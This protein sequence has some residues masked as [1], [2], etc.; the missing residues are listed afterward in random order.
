MSPSPPVP[1]DGRGLPNGHGRRLLRLA[2]ALVAGPLLALALLALMQYLVTQPRDQWLE[3]QERPAIDFVRVKSETAPVET[4]RRTPPPEPELEPPP[5]TPSL[6]MPD[7]ARP[8]MPP[9]HMGVGAIEVPVQVAEAP[10]LGQAGPGVAAGSGSRDVMAISRTP[11]LYPISA[12]RRGI[13]GW[14]ELAFTVTAAGSVKDVEVV[15][16]EPP[17]VFD[18][19]AISAIYRWKFRPRT[20][21]GRPVSARVSQRLSFE[22]RR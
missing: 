15:R 21:D 20:V 4:R 5:A 1:I 19:A 11:P 8:Q 3:A 18:Q 16:A 12:K 13:E 7:L 10:Y 17:G 6:A 9:M 2:T 22:L 14:V